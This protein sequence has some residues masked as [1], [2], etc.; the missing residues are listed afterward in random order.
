MATAPLADRQL[1]PLVAAFN[2]GLRMNALD[3]YLLQAF[4]C[5]TQWHGEEAER[6]L[7][8]LEFLFLEL[9]PQDRGAGPR[10]LAKKFKKEWHAWFGAERFYEDWLAVVSPS[11]DLGERRSVK[12]LVNE[13]AFRVPRYRKKIE[14]SLRKRLARFPRMILALQLGVC[15]DEG[16]RPPC[17]KYRLLRK[18]TSKEWRRWRDRSAAGTRSP[19]P[20]KYEFVESPRKPGEIAPAETSLNELAI[21]WRRAGLPEA[22]LPDAGDIPQTQDG[23]RALDE[24]LVGKAL[25]ALGSSDAFDPEIDSAEAW[26]P[27]PGWHF[28]EGEFAIGGKSCLVGPQEFKFVQT[29]VKARRTLTSNELFKSI[30]GDESADEP[31][32]KYKKLQNLK[33]RVKKKVAAS[34]NPPALRIVNEGRG[35]EGRWSIKPRYAPGDRQA[36]A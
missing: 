8:E 26:P 6:I 22:N 27:D 17:S 34:P 20:M 11:F 7:E 36:N 15:V 32:E 10:R 18:V 12:S 28:R 31:N 19:E 4:V 9:F 3:W 14:Q 30:W 2:V 35:F 25:A 16:L 29:L 5:C 23:R 21:L 13:L 24:R 33:A 1:H